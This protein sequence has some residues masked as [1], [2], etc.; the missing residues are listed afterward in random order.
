MV[1][2]VFVLVSLILIFIVMYRNSS[3]KNIYKYITKSMGPVYDKVA[4]YTY[5][6]IR[7]KIKDLGQNYTLKDYVSQILI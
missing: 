3:G 7:K 6:E 4:P 2:L 1:N 5:Q